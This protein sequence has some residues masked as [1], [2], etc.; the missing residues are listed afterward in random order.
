MRLD[1]SGR[2]LV[3]GQT[4]QKPGR[5]GCVTVRLMTA[6]TTVPAAGSGASPVTLI[7]TTP[8]APSGAELRVSSSRSAVGKGTYALVV[9]A[10]PATAVGN[11]AVVIA[12]VTAAPPKV[13][14]RSP[15][16]AMNF[17]VRTPKS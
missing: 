3:W 15:R 17:L 16:V 14:P 9:P 8:F 10:A 7:E 4:V 2:A 5:I 13:A 12:V 1:A 6:A 11:T